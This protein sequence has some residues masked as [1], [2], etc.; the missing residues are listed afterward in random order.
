ML[1]SR[2]VM[3]W[4]WFEPLFTASLELKVPSEACVLSPVNNK[5]ALKGPH[6]SDPE[7]HPEE[8]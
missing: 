7:T 1:P 4:L 6:L 5:P 8:G 2:N 3:F